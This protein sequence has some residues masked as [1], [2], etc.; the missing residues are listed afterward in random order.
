M[1]CAPLI[2]ARVV[3]AVW[4]QMRAIP[5][6]PIKCSITPIKLP[7]A[8]DL[9]STTAEAQSLLL[10]HSRLCGEGVRCESCDW[11]FGVFITPF[12]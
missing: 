3:P 6:T 10:F 4:S 11:M 9:A 7:P 8:W 2:A 1:D 12:Y 5:I